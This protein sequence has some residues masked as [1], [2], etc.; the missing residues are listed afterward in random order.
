MASMKLVVFILI[1][2]LF[3]VGCSKSSISDNK[4]SG[5]DP[6][7]NPAGTYI[8]TTLN[9]WYE[10]SDYYDSVNHT[11]K[12]E[13]HL[14]G[15]SSNL[16]TIRVSISGTTISFGS[17]SF[18]KNDSNIYSKTIGLWPS[19]TYYYYKINSNDHSL[20]SVTNFYG[21]ISPHYTSDV[22]TFTGF[23]Q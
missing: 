15:T 5:P 7:P 21:G 4:T 18:P 17:E 13:Y 22:S 20:K 12:R 6:N 8:G 23:Q 3:G 1:V 2:I 19:H 16:D 9:E 11:W 14:V 10:G